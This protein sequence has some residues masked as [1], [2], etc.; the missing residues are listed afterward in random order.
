MAPWVLFTILVFGPCE[1]LIPL[2]MYPA[3]KHNIGG[4]VLVAT[5]FGAFTVLTM[6]AMVLLGVYGLTFLPMNKMERYSHALAGFAILLC[7]L[8]IVFL[9]L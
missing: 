6:L 5:V 7:G 3:A 4:A 1:P 2:L 8:S 9:G